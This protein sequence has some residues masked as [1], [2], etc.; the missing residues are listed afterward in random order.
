MIAGNVLLKQQKIILN[1]I[2]I[3]LK[4]NNY[5][6]SIHIHSFIDEPQSAVITGLKYKFKPKEIHTVHSTGHCE[7]F[8]F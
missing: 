2:N 5:V 4:N 8:G 3:S 1:H 7:F 6:A